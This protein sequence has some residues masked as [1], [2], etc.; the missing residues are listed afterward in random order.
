MSLSS[1]HKEL[2][3]FDV[4]KSHKSVSTVLC[5][6]AIFIQEIIA[7]DSGDRAYRR[8]A[9]HSKWIV[10]TTINH[11]TKSLIALSQL[12]D[13]KMVVVGDRTTPRDWV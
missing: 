8:V 12:K 4:E 1:I 9:T 5:N 11:P 7:A 10:V 13:W 6:H 3:A 2:V